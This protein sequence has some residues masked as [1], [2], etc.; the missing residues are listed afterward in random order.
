MSACIITA[1][2]ISYRI[3]IATSEIASQKTNAT[4][5]RVVVSYALLFVLKK[6]KLIKFKLS[7]FY[8]SLVSSLNDDNIIT[9]TNVNHA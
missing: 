1:D 7:T 8:I 9:I 4:V 2:S 3:M 6:P 5:T